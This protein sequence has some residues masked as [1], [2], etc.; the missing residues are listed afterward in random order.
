MTTDLFTSSLVEQARALFRELEYQDED[1]RIA[2]LNEL[3][4][5]LHRY[6]PFSEEPVDC[7]QWIPVE[8]VQANDYNPNTVASDPS[9]V[10]T[11][12]DTSDAQ[13]RED[14]SACSP[15]AATLLS[16]NVA[17]AALQDRCMTSRGYTTTRWSR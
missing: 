5:E 13:R 10:Y 17:V 12:T 2:T 6:S 4:R 1:T 15:P 14:F 16:G 11:R 3:R 7:V 8:A 9:W